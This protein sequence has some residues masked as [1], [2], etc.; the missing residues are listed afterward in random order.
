MAAVRRYLDDDGDGDNVVDS[1]VDS[2]SGN[3]II[4]SP[5]YRGNEAEH[6]GIVCF[7]LGY[8][9]QICFIHPLNLL[10]FIIFYQDSLFLEFKSKM[11][12]GD[13]QI[14]LQSDI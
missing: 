1:T 5:I 3:F 10:P 6:E 2:T 4:P 8:S 7:C 13:Q 14:E 12:L 11:K 9:N